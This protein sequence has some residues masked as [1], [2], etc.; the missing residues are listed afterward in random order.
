MDL[1][2]LSKNFEV[3]RS[4]SDEEVREYIKEAERRGDL[5]EGGVLE[6]EKIFE[7]MRE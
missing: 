1:K 5:P 2:Q 3:I 6:L 4:L 7:M